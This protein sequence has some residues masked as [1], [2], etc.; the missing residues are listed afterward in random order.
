MRVYC[1]RA[2]VLALGLGV[3]A[4]AGVDEETA[5]METAPSI[6]SGVEIEYVAHASFLLHGDDGTQ[7][8]IDPFASRVWLGY[9]WPEGI[10]PDA[11]LITHPHYDHDAGRYREM[12][13]PWSEALPIFDAPGHAVFGD[14]AVTGVEGKHADPYGMEFGQLNTLMLI[15]VGGLRIAHLGDNGPLTPGM[16]EGLGRVDV[17]MLPADG[18]YHIIS[19]E[20]TQEI[21]AALAPRIVIPMH[22]RLAD[23]EA[24]ADA[25]SDLGD[26][27]P[28][29]D[30]RPGVERVGSHRLRI[31]PSDL[32]T[33]PAGNPRILVFEHAPY[34]RSPG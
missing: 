32:T 25:P 23:L 2:F 10:D 9:D 3:A 33:T 28:W 8:L 16:V 21:L 24:E 19:E 30:G 34:V 4:C 18:V 5:A 12:P 13:F 14:I 22:Y 7:V 27:D 31:S 17:L 6:E 1:G 15:E 29:L 26:I 11:I 20:T